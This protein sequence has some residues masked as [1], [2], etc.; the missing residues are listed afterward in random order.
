MAPSP[1]MPPI[2][3]CLCAVALSSCCRELR[4]LGAA[5]R[6]RHLCCAACGHVLCDAAQALTSETHREA[7][8]LRL[9]DGDSVAL[10]PLH[11]TGCTLSGEQP[12]EALETL[13][14][15]RAS[16]A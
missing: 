6:R 15:L 13:L 7:P 4:A 12:L 8:A 16:W 2:L 14:C 11:C 5:A 3:P 9:P 1:P 10:D